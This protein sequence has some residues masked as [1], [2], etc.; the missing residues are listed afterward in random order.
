MEVVLLHDI[1]EAEEGY[2]RP[3]TAEKP[4]AGEELRF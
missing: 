2:F 3:E 4:S 1:V